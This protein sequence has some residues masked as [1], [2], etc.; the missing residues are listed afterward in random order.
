MNVRMNKSKN[1]QLS[2]TYLLALIP[3]LEYI[4][5]KFSNKKSIYMQLQK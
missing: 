5:C 1:L 3:I 4:I 2:V